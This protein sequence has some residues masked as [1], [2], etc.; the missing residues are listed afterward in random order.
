M[1]PGSDST[2]AP[3][4]NISRYINC[5]YSSES[6]DLDNLCWPHLQ[7]IQIYVAFFPLNIKHHQ[8]NLLH[9]ISLSLVHNL[10]PKYSKSWSGCLITLLCRSRLGPS[11]LH[12]GWGYQHPW[13]HCLPQVI[14]RSWPHE[15]CPWLGIWGGA[16]VLSHRCQMA[17]KARGC[18]WRGEGGR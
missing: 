11:G 17:S 3:E 16:E 4:A 1:L 2:I 12:H 6:V 9:Y 14:P 15:L 18:R 8:N 13:C 10:F 7:T 5:F